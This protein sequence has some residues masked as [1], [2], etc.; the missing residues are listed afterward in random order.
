MFKYLI[1][2]GYDLWK[3]NLHKSKSSHWAWHRW[4][5]YQLDQLKNKDEYYYYCVEMR[6]IED[7]QRYKYDLDDTIILL[8]KDS[9]SANEELKW[10]DIII[11]ITYWATYLHIYV[12]KKCET[13][14]KRGRFV[15]AWN[16]ESYFLII[17]TDDADEWGY[18]LINSYGCCKYLNIGSKFPSTIPVKFTYINRFNFLFDDKFKTLCCTILLYLKHFKLPRLLIITQIFERVCDFERQILLDNLF[19]YIFE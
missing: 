16:L 3:E 14:F 5:E 9:K 18:C 12:N 11:E 7:N 13:I 6:K 10:N 15:E 4:R 17:V 19:K 2:D 1:Y 8:G